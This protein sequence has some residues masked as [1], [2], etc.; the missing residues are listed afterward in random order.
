MVTDVLTLE[1]LRGR[2]DEILAVAHRRRARKVAV[3][4]SVAR[5]EARPGSDIDF[6]V[7]FEPEASLLDHVGLLQDLE[8][9]LGIGVDVVSRGGLLPRD[10]RI[11]NEAVEL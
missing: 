3:F 10:E 6:L 9:L 4:G 1:G 5:G 8:D 7:D 11:R 2:R